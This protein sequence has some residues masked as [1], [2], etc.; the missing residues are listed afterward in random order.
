M[1]R[2]RLAI[3]VLGIGGALALPA[4]AH[5][6]T[7]ARFQVGTAV[8]DIT[9]SAPQYLGGYDHMD[10]PTAD[11]HDPLQV[12]AFFVAHGH[13][14][15]GFVAVDTQGWFAGYQEGPYGA[16]N[17]AKDAAGWLRGHGYDVNTG[18]LIFSSSH[19]HAA[20]T[21]MGIWGPTDPRYLK[22][23]HDAAVQAI[24]QAARHTR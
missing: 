5:A 7:P 6:A 23:V 18:N 8:V 14:A 20:P 22:Q 16:R 13:Q 3:A 4:T 1:G 17:A 15:V 12:R 19:S 21:I 24:E 11:A 10:T 9:P 2:W